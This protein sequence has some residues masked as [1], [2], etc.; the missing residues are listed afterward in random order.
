MTGTHA[1]VNSSLLNDSESMLGLCFDGSCFD[2]FV[3]CEVT[4][5]KLLTRDLILV[6]AYLPASE[7]PYLSDASSAK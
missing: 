3:L 1:V 4:G 2:A 7:R 6:A 5:I